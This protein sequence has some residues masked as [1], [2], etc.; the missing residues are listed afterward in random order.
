MGELGEDAGQL[1]THAGTVNNHIDSAM[2]QQELTTL[3][4][5]WQLLSDSL[6]NDIRA[7]N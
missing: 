4:A 2:I 3:K 6:L 5:F 7:C 1:V